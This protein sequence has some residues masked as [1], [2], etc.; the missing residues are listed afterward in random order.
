MRCRL[1]GDV[2][3]SNDRRESV[4]VD[5]REDPRGHELLHPAARD[6]IGHFE[7]ASDRR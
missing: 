4:I 1:A 5:D 6:R 7:R 3:R 2:P